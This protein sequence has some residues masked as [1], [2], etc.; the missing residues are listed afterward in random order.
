MH[1]VAT[2]PR[3]GTWYATYVL[4][5]Y[6]QLLAGY[7]I[8]LARMIKEQNNEMK[9]IVVCHRCGT[10]QKPF[11]IFGYNWGDEVYKQTPTSQCFIYRKKEA[12]IESYWKHLQDADHIE[13]GSKEK[14]F[15]RASE[16]YDNMISSWEGI[17][18]LKITYEEIQE[19]PLFNFA[20]I[21]NNM[22][23]IPNEKKLIEAIEICKL[24]NIKK[25]EIEAGTTLAKDVKRKHHATT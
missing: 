7:P 11:K 16:C 12:Q 8:D 23:K 25:A 17:D 1:L 5:C 9:D 14:F 3:S 15:Q 2:I 20:K 4:S 19:D 6:T 24:E 22:G 13:T 18:C 10:K 21:I